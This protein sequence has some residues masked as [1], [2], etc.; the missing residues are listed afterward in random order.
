MP[1]SVENP[2]GGSMIPLDGGNTNSMARAPLEEPEVGATFKTLTAEQLEAYDPHANYSENTKA[3]LRA[4]AE[5]LLPQL[6]PGD[7]EKL[8][9]WLSQ[10][11]TTTTPP[12][13]GPRSS[14]GVD[15]NSLNPTDLAHIAAFYSDHTSPKLAYIALTAFLEPGSTLNP[16]QNRIFHDLAEKIAQEATNGS[17]ADLQDLGS[18]DPEKIKAVLIRLYGGDD[19]EILDLL[20]GLA[21]RLADVNQSLGTVVDMPPATGGSPD[22]GVALPDTDPAPPEIALAPNEV[23]APPDGGAV[24]PPDGGAAPPDGGAV[25]PE[26]GPVLPGSSGGTT[27]TTTTTTTST[28]TTSATPGTGGTTSTSGV[29]GTTATTGLNSSTHTEATPTATV[30]I[31]PSAPAHNPY[32]DPGFMALLAKILSEVQQ[33]EKDNIIMGAKLLVSLMKASLEMALTSRDDAIASGELQAQQSE[34]EARK[35]HFASKMEMISGGL[36]IAS[37]GL[38]YVVSTAAS[39]RVK[40]KDFMVNKNTQAEAQIGDADAVL[41]KGSY[42]KAQMAAGEMA[43]NT[44]SG[45][46]QG[47]TQIVSGFK[48]AQAGDMDEAKAALIREA[49]QFQG[50]QQLLDKLIQTIQQSIS[51]VREDKSAI[52][53]FQSMIDLIKSYQQLSSSM[54]SR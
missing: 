19:P 44:L 40:E 45:L 18:T 8:T 28:E 4:A 17:S 42:M 46:T 25:L 49:A 39:S 38:T 11:N 16:E 20:D 35:E 14:I 27:T 6:P 52:Q 36:T 15:L 26:E 53:F 43:R 7:Q 12:P 13:A 31:L 47:I 10:L 9:R 34:L 32:C 51:S 1:I 54:W 33:I 30:V 2:S 23:A 29:S 37:A 22:A 41:D 21:K 5:D 3:K 50:D 48:D 24:V